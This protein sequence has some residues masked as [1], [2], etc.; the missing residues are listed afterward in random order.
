MKNIY[1]TDIQV[2]N[3]EYKLNELELGKNKS[4]ETFED[5]SIIKKEKE[6][7]TKIIPFEFKLNENKILP[8]FQYIN[9]DYILGIR[10]L[11]IADCKEYNSSN[12]TGL[13][14][15]KNKNIELSKEKK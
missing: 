1:K 4:S 12:Y 15:G 10:H 7:K 2:E 9:K 11:L 8:T 14:I 3:I 6:D 5:F 13:F